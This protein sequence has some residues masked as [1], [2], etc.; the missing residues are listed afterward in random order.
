[1]GEFFR[2]N[3]WLFWIATLW[4]IGYGINSTVLYKR[5]EVRGDKR[6]RLEQKLEQKLEQTPEQKLEQKKLEL[7]LQGLPYPIYWY[8]Y[9]FI[10]N[11]LGAFTGWVA[12]YFLLKPDIVEF[13]FRHFV[14]LVIAY[15]GIT[16]NL[17]Q[18]SIAGNIFR[19]Q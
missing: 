16:G 13:D 19:R 9:Q 2:C 4:A 12:L 10:F 15:L 18:V 17:P 6:K 5:M 14:A 8:V 7:D 1:M 3:N 11:G